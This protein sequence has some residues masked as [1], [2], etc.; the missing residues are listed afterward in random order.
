MTEPSRTLWPG[1]HGS[2]QFSLVRCNSFHAHSTRCVE[3]R[4]SMLNCAG[5]VL[6]AGVNE[7]SSCHTL[8]QVVNLLQ[9]LL[10]HALQYCWHCFKRTR[11]SLLLDP[12]PFPESM[13]KCWSFDA[14]WLSW[15]GL[16]MSTSIQGATPMAIHLM[17]LCT[18]VGDLYRVV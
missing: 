9:V 12:L 15:G 11:C 6:F 7:R 3:I 2:I 13:Q 17:E 18:A 14:S 16:I 10:S 8:I 1:C 5:M 4:K